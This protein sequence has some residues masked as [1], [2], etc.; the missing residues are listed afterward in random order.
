MKCGACI[1][2]CPQGAKFIS[3]AG[4]LY[5]RNELEEMYRRRALSAIYV[6]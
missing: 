4:Y 3:D 6:S 1:K 5:H 2:K